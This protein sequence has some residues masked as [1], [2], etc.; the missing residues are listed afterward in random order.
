MRLKYY[1]LTLRQI[2]YERL[3]VFFL[4]I[5]LPV[6]LLT[7][8][9]NKNLEPTISS[10][11]ESNGRMIALKATN[12]TVYKH[13]QGVSY[14]NLINIQKDNDNNIVALVANAVEINKISSLV[15]LDVQNY[16]DN[17]TES[18]VT[19]PIGSILGIKLFGGYGPKINL[20]TIPVGDVETKFKS[21]FSDA[22]INQTKHS[23]IIEVNVNIKI[24]APFYTE[25]KTYNNS[26][27]VA[28]T[29]IIGNTPS[30]YYNIEGID[31]MNKKDAMD[32]IN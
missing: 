7:Y 31:G 27:L 24:L 8:F 18:K 10:I 13:I 30:S 28:E 14:E 32:I 2:S 3:F 4:F 29:V 21:E 17:N 23:I 9:F 20:K 11:C 5:A 26:I 15:S 1:S 22:G 12:D 16:L 19:L 25:T 6:V